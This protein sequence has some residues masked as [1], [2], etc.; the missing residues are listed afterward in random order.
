VC[1]RKRDKKKVKKKSGRERGAC[2]GKEC[3]HITVHAHQHPPKNKAGKKAKKAKKKS[4]R[5]RKYKEALL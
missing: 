2:V 4:H 1:I 3:H 5:P